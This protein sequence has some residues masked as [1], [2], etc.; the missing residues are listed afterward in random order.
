MYS[1]YSL[2]H[3]VKMLVGEVVDEP[4]FIHE[5]MHGKVFRKQVKT[6]RHRNFLFLGDFGGCLSQ[7]KRKHY[8]DNVRTEN[9]VFY[10]IFFG[11]G[12]RNPV[13]RE[14]SVKHA[15]IPVRYDEVP[16]LTLFARVGAE[17]LHR[18]SRFL[19]IAYKIH[20]GYGNAVVFR[21]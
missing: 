8:M 21:T 1:V 6:R 9:R 4:R 15:E 18:V 20:R 13:F 5:D 10:N 3:T 14:V 16:L 2:I 17:Y 7:R 11:C 19:E 12:E